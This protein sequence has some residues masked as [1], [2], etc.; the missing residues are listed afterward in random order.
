MSKIAIRRKERAIYNERKRFSGRTQ[1]KQEKAD[2]LF[3]IG[4]SLKFFVR[5]SSFGFEEADDL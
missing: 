5:G 1:C 2:K 4:F 3:A